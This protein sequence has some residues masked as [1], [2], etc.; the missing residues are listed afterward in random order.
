M[1]NRE[2]TNIPEYYAATEAAKIIGISYSG[3]VYTMKKY[4]LNPDILANDKPA[5]A[6]ETLI[7]WHNNTVPMPGGHKKSPLP[8]KG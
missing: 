8:T 2:P 6:K 3:F 7:N 1:Q 5:W 4:P